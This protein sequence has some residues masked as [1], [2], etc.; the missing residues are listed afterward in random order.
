MALS[1]SESDV[2]LNR[3]NVA[4][5]RSQRLVA[6]WLPEKTGDELTSAKSEE[7][8]QREEDEIF[9]AV[10]ETLGVGAPLPEKAADGSWN[11]T[12]LSSNDQL[13]KQLLGRNYDKFMKASAAAKQASAA[14]KS[15]ASAVASGASSAVQEEDDQDDDED[16]R[17][18]MVGKKKRR[19]GQGRAAQTGSGSGVTPV[20]TPGDVEDAGAKEE[21]GVVQTDAPVKQA[22]SKG[23]KKATSYLDELLAERSKKRKKR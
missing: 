17:V 20:S 11:R 2:I 1:K 23:R 15:T 9:T 13:R 18:S 10:P 8:L 16:G 3:A 21:N 4:L 19:V 12:E 7:E 6:S 22:P 5:A 14:A